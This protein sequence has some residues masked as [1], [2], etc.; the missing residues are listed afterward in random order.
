[1]VA[2]KIEICPLIMVLAPFSWPV[3]VDFALIKESTSSRE[4]T[5]NSSKEFVRLSGVGYRREGRQVLSDIS[6]TSNARSIGVVGSNGSGKSSLT[7]LLTGLDEPTDG[8][9]RI[10]G[11][12]VFEDRAFALSHIGM[13]FQNPDQQIIFP[14]VGEE[15]RFGLENLGIP[16]EEIDNRVTEVLQRFRLRDWEVIPVRL[17][18]HGQK[19]L[20][21]LMSIL[22]MQ[23]K[24]IVFDEP[25]SSLDIQM[26]HRMRRILSTLDVHIILISHNPVDLEEFDELIWLEHGR[27]EG[28]GPVSEIMPKY[29]EYARKAAEQ[30]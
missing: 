4:K 25:Y 6:L 15:L 2:P 19:H 9:V 26:A 16:P 8:E 27:L 13:I 29:L 28:H 18:S 20:L 23:P 1:M 24:A 10:F 5:D 30:C 7:R 3:R 22:V 12:D 11:R 14:T 17:L 21:C